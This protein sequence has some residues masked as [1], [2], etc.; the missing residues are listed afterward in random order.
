MSLHI[1]AVTLDYFLFAVNSEGIKKIG[2][3]LST[4]GN[5]KQK[6]EKVSHLSI[7]S[8]CAVVMWCPGS[9]NSSVEPVFHGN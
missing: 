7:N 6:L 5:E 9:K 4:L 2:S 3:S 1:T 8:V